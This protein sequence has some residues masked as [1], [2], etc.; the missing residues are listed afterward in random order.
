MSETQ[1]KQ[2]PTW[3][4]Y[5]ACYVL[6]I[7]LIVAGAATLFL[8]LRPALLALITALLGQ[9]QANRL[10]YAGAITLLGL[11]LFIFVMAAEPYLRNGIARRQLLRRFLRLAIPIVIAAIIG[12]LMLALTGQIA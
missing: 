12:L 9:S 2:T 4:A 1:P 10:V 8:I 11:G 6:Y 3:Q 5:L 7:L